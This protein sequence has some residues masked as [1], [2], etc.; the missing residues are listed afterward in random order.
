MLWTFN[1]LIQ[2]RQSSI[3]NYMPFY[4]GH[5]IIF[6]DTGPCSGGRAHGP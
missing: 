4:Q 2:Q 3:S 1:F 6:F 5:E